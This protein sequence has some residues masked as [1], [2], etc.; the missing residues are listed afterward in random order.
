[1]AEAS[2]YIEGSGRKG[3]IR[4]IKARTIRRSRLKRL[5]YTPFRLSSR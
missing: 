3:D 1:M 2:L 5:I 4:V